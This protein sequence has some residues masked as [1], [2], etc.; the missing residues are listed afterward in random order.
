M[1]ILLHT[2]MLHRLM[3]LHTLL[4][5]NYVVIAHLDV[6]YIDALVHIDVVMY[7]NV[8]AGADK[9]LHPVLPGGMDSD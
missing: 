7:V 1:L 6:T 4:L 2:L 5:Y 8:L 3:L 9:R